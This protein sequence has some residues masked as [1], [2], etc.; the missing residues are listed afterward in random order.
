MRVKHKQSLRVR[1]SA[2]CGRGGRL[3]SRSEAE[4]EVVHFAVNFFFVSF[5][6]F[7]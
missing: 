6:L 2:K 5:F 1:G 7:G 4:V 3:L